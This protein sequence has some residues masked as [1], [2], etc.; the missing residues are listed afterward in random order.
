MNATLTTLSAA[1]LA[2]LLAA[3]PASAADKPWDKE[4]SESEWHPITFTDRNGSKHTVYFYYPD[5]EEGKPADAAENRAADEISLYDL[6]MFAATGE[7]IGQARPSHYVGRI[8]KAQK[9]ALG[10]YVG[11]MVALPGAAFEAPWIEQPRRAGATITVN[12]PTLGRAPLAET[13]F[14]DNGPAPEASTPYKREELDA[15]S[16]PA[17][18]ISYHFLF[19]EANWAGRFPGIAKSLKVVSIKDF[20]KKQPMRDAFDEGDTDRLH[21]AVA[22]KRAEM[23][24]SAET[25]HQKI[26]ANEA[27]QLG[28]FTKAEGDLLWALV[29]ISK[30][31][32]KFI[33]EL[34]ATLAL[35]AAK[36]APFVKKYRT[37]LKAELVRYANR[38]RALKPGQLSV[39]AYDADVKELVG[40]VADTIEDDPTQLASN[41][42]PNAKAVAVVVSKPAAAKPAGTTPK[43]QSLDGIGQVFGN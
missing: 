22:G 11:M 19:Q 25:T 2:V 34:D 29:G 42:N 20:R 40:R 31:R 27:A 41:A 39:A 35:E 38:A 17:E 24:A 9:W 37:L 28:H 32:S 5:Y 43:F 18:H 13:L 8:V 12:R 16:I 1:T 21:N 36:R 7:S 4:V 23:V 30:K 26:E 6:H 15:D 14:P 3:A 10:G 33:A